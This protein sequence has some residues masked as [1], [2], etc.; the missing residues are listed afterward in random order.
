MTAISRS[1]V[2]L[3]IAPAGTNPSALVATDKI[4]GEIKSYTLSGGEDEVESDAVFG[5]YVDKEKPQSQFEVEMEVVPSL[6]SADRWDALIWGQKGSTY[7]GDVSAANKMI[8]IQAL[9]GTSL[10]KSWAF[11]NCNGVA[12]EREHNADDNM[13]GTFRFKISPAT[14]AGVSNIQT[15]AVA[16]TAL[17][18]WSALTS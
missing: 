16:I 17:S 14:S 13:T 18:A 9:S 11:N 6:E 15:K 2:S 4:T 7:V 12:F 3:Y 10:F 5:G 1:T 8:G